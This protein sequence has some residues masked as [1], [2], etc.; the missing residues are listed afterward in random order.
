[1]SQYRV[2]IYPCNGRLFTAASLKEEAAIAPTQIAP[3]AESTARDG[4]LQVRGRYANVDYGFRVDVPAGLVGEGSTPPAPNHG[5]AIEFGEKSVLCVDASYE[6]P[7]SPHVF[8]RFNARLGKLQAE[9]RSWSDSE[10]GIKLLHESIVARG[11]D[12][13]TPIIYTIQLDT[14]AEHQS[15]GLRVLEALTASS[16]TIPVRP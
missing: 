10:G 2:K 6:M 14:T 9:R 1:L 11:F 5:F 3:K 4:P 13:H 16:R 8:H 12:R 15:D 7:D